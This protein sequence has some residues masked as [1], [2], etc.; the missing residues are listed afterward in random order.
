ML[1]EI[2]YTLPILQD[3]EGNLEYEKLTFVFIIV[4][5]ILMSIVIMNLLIGLAVGDID[6]IQRNAIAEKR[7][8]EVGIFTRLDYS[9]PKRL[10]QKYDRNSYISFP[11][12]KRS[13]IR[14]LW[15]IFW[16]LLKGEGDGDI[17]DTTTAL[18]GDERMTQNQLLASQLQLMRDRLDDL[19]QVQQ[20][21]LDVVQKL[22]NKEQQQ[23]DEKIEEP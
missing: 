5:A 9:M 6:Q 1:G 15:K 8:I 23:Q 17:F 19:T 4:V 20:N 22:Q 10:L 14:K 16:N 3:K 12:A 21:L 7:T 11:N 13:S 2:D 18:D